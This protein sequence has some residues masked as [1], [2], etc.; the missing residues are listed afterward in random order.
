MHDN[1]S[2]ETTLVC[3]ARTPLVFD[4]VEERVE[5]A[6]ALEE[7]HLVDNVVVRSWPETVRLDDDGPHREVVEEFRR[8][9]EWAE[10]RGVSV[11]PP[12]ETRTRTSIVEEDGVEV[13]VT[14]VLCLALYRDERLVSVFPHSDADETYTVD[15]VLDR[16]EAD[17]L[18]RP[19]SGRLEV[20]DARSC[21]E[22]EATLLKGQGLFI[23]P[24]CAW[25]GTIST[26]GWS[27]LEPVDLGPRAPGVAGGSHDVTE[28]SPSPS[29]GAPT[30]DEAGAD[31]S[32]SS[33]DD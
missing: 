6:Q 16:L 17:E 5:R 9:E 8:Y 19:L 4:P 18:P 12:F 28:N 24:D 22:C 30:P 2:T 1:R 33:A 11:S 20:P 15:R 13:L 32:A 27:D 25:T 23:C 3:H 26:E 14:P 21:P 10:H 29:A 31:D 7:G